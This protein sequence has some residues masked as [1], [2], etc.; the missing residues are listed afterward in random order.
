MVNTKQRIIAASIEL[1]NER[2][3]RNVTTN[4]IAAYLG[5]SPG[6]LYYHFRNK[7]DI[8]DAIYECYLEYIESCFMPLPGSLPPADRII[9]Y[10][11]EVFA[12]IWQFR[13]FYTSLPG[14]LQQNA[15]LKQR[16]IR[17]QR[18]LDH[19]AM[20]ILRELCS[21]GA[22]RINAPDTHRLV[23]TLRIVISFWVSYCMTDTLDERVSR[24]SMQAGL[25]Q[26]LFVLR[27]YAG[28]SVAEEI[29]RLH[30][31][32]RQTELRS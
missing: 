23:V 12:G 25:L 8:I 26:A 29:D 24:D 2:G 31:L 17:V 9:R 4:H 13:F 1:F 10:L 11:E 20:H 5:I 19:R 6:N 14:I 30:R 3:E 27:P 32:A 28:D 22:L 15:A 16:Y 21:L 18:A 7:E